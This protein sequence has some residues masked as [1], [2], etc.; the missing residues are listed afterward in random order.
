MPAL[1]VMCLPSASR[2][3]KITT[4]SFKFSR[5]RSP[6]LNTSS[7]SPKPVTFRPCP[8]PLLR[9]RPL[10]AQ[11]TDSQEKTQ[12]ELTAE[13]LAN[14][15]REEDLEEVVETFLFNSRFLAAFGVVGALFGSLTMFVAGT[16]NIALS[17]R[18][19]SANMFNY[20]EFDP[21]AGI[22]EAIDNYL[23]A[24][25]LLVFG[26]GMY[27][28]FI[29][30]IDDI[31]FQKAHLQLA[32]GRPNWLKTKGLDDLK[33]KLGKVIIMVF[34]VKSL[35]YLQAMEVESV[36]DLLYATASVCLCS[37]SLYLAG[38]GKNEL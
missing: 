12:E 3:L 10:Y 2:G 8:R 30:E 24:T 11:E 5:S 9:G 29:S 21:S 38:L 1:N 16:K 19:M 20:V 4:H 15:D 37:I 26:L 23:L 28:L 27:E 34:L 14:T 32:E 36:T 35:G 31:V 18:N 25:V 17:G 13:F 33:R 6:F 22:I 7:V